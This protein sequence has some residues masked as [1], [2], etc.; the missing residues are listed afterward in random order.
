MNS[1][2]VE[3]QIVAVEKKVIQELGLLPITTD[4]YFMKVWNHLLADE[5]MLSDLTTA[6]LESAAVTASLELQT[7]AET[8]AS[9][10]EDKAQESNVRA[11]RAI[12]VSLR[13]EHELETI[14]RALFNSISQLEYIERTCP[15]GARPEALNTHPH[16]GGCGISA[17]LTL[18]RRYASR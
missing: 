18:A 15:C 4:P 3:A 17:L 6:T 12:E 13:A 5:M 7:A 11:E 8:R 14:K 9:L 10:A 1:P 2:Q 16:V